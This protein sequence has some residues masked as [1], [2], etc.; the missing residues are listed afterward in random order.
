MLQHP[1]PV[2]KSIYGSEE[3]CLNSNAVIYTYIYI[4]IV[5]IAALNQWTSYDNEGFC[6]KIF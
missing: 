5:G 2:G 1:P 4:L 3:D 6:T